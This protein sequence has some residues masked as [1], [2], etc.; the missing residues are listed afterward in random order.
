MQERFQS[1]GANAST[2]CIAK[3]IEQLFVSSILPSI[4]IRQYQ[5]LQLYRLIFVNIVNFSKMSR[6]L[7]SAASNWHFFA[8]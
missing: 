2:C 1:A 6:N 3:F 4:T 8:N 7:S 5:F